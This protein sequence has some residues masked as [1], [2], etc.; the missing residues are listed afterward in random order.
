MAQPLI[1]WRKTALEHVREIYDYLAEN[2]SVN[3]ADEFLDRIE[4][5]VVHIVQYPTTGMP[6]QRHKEVRSYRIDGRRRLYY[7]STKKALTIL[8]IFD[9]KQDPSKNKF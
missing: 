7:K 3:V 8:G 5:V 9:S 6:S 4:E 1:L 2:A